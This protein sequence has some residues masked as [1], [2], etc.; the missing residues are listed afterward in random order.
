M[1]DT[2]TTTTTT[3]AAETQV[4]T[5]Q[6]PTTTQENE[7][8][9][10]T[11]EEL[12]AQLASERAEKE[13]YKNASDKASSEAAQYKKQLRSKQTAE[14]QEAEAK[15][16]A[17]RL[18]NERYENAIKELNHMKAVSAYKNVSEKSIETLIEAVAEGDHSAI[19]TIIDNEVKAAVANAKA[20]WMKSRPP[21]NIGSI[22]D[23][24]PTKEEF[25]RMNYSKRVEFKAKHP[26]LYKKYTE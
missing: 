4:N 10:P 8:K 19:A 22:D 1:A 14:E 7:T 20:E 13:K 25:A 2:N 17:E 3:K 21:V 5:G 26:E 11:V 12:M 18:Q 6:E 15:A 24:A 9:T 23:N 16:E